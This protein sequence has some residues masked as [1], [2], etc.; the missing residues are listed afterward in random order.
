[1]IAVLEAF[2]M[3]L[4]RCFASVVLPAGQLTQFHE[5]VQLVT[6][7]TFISLYRL[8]I[9]LQ[10][11]YWLSTGLCTKVSSLQVILRSVG[12][13]YLGICHSDRTLDQLWDHDLV[14]PS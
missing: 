3:Q 2:A 10:H 11:N 4:Q 12:K 6:R 7:Y 14:N 13:S 9:K 8:S 1:M 5:F